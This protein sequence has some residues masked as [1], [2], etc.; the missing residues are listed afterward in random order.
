[1][2]HIG[3]HPRALAAAGR[4]LQA[5]VFIRGDHDLAMAGIGADEGNAGIMGNV[6]FQNV[7]KIHPAQHI[8]VRNGKIIRIGGLQVA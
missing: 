5:A 6:V 2:I 3:E 4:L 1:M 8:A 7:G